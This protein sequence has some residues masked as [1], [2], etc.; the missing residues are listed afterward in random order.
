LLAVEHKPRRRRAVDIGEFKGLVTAVG[1]AGAGE[2]AEVGRDLLLEVGA[3]ARDRLG[4]LGVVPERGRKGAA[5]QLL[6]L[7]PQLRDVKDAPLAP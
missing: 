6:G 2:D 7:G 5:L 1:P 3:P 4:F